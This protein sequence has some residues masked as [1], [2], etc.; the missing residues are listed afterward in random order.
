MGRVVCDGKFFA[1]EGSRFAFHGCTYGTFAPRSDGALFPEREVIQ[2]DFR[3]MTDAGFNVV[4]T[5]TTPPDDLLECAAETGLRILASVHYPDWRYLLGSSRRDR[6]RLRIESE[7]NVRAEARR[8]RGNETVLAIS[9]GNE[10]PADVVRWYGANEIA[11][12]I[13]TLV[14]CVR[15]EDPDMLVTY[16]NFPTTE[17]LPLPDVDFVTFN[18]FLEHEADFRRYL[19]RLHN[20]AGERPLVLGEIGVD[21]S[22][23]EERQASM[24]DWQLRV[25]LERGV[26]GAC[27][28]SWT[29]EW[30]VGRPINDWQFG[31]TRADRSQRPAHAVARK[32]NQTRVADLLQEW[33]SISLVVCAYNA[34][35]TL[36]ECLRH[37]TGLDYPGLEVLVVDDGSTDETPDIVERFPTVRLVRTQRA[38]LGS[39]RNAGYAAAQ[40]HLVAYI[41]S[42]AYPTPE[43]PYYM[44]LG[45]DSST[46]CGVGG[47]NVAPPKDPVGAQRVARA[48]GG[49]IHVLV[50]DDRAEHLPGCNM[51]FW[52]PVLEEAG[53]FDPAYTA[54]GDDVDI[55]WKLL[56]RGWEI[57]FHPA[58]L[59]WHHRRAGVIDYLRQQ[60]GY[61][62]AEALV[63]ARHPDRYTALGS[64]RWK[65][66]IYSPMAPSLMRQR[67]Y[68]GQYGSAAYQSVY[69]GGGHALDI[70]H[71][72]GVP[73]ALLIMATTPLALLKPLVATPAA[74][75]VAYLL[76]LAVVD[77]INATP[78]RDLRSGRLWFR[79][80]LAGLHLLQPI[81][82]LWGHLRAEPAAR[83]EL[84]GSLAAPGPVRR[85]GRGV[86]L[87]PLDRPRAELVAWVVAELRRA[88]L[89]IETATGWDDYDARIIGS[90]FVRGELLTSGHPLGSMQLRVRRR[91][92]FIPLVSLLVLATAIAPLAL[93]VAAAL[94]VIVGAE[95][96]RGMW[97]TGAVVT[98]SLEQAV[99]TVA[100]AKQLPS[101]RSAP[102]E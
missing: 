90:T 73:F 23:S 39:A 4:R 14:E 35:G 40:G 69:R 27:I 52:K 18:V 33:P 75:G 47:P 67:V 82:R 5:Y 87:V 26:A 16:A 43:W 58:A 72:A 99:A 97:R 70:A 44:A 60:L 3:T 92:R 2:S 13:S 88:G 61:G 80:G 24:L 45:L 32:W 65:G 93:P 50:S 84:P 101:T 1:V 54:A 9:V 102:V 96:A 11:S 41:D 100:P 53:G 34:R 42:D 38:G 74:L 48:P 19:T 85:L 64:A 30:F 17:Y 59:V 31:L 55:C 98:R 95:I 56:N 29:D 78:P 12:T 37:A 7:R 25:A 94:L 62:R 21:A 22:V 66:A 8:L 76:A 6:R 89:R 57:A 46:V 63:Q 71:Q 36:D 51:A 91:L 20:L 83:R 77:A 15:D 86:L 81:F 10:V 68:R 79:L 49:P 28:F